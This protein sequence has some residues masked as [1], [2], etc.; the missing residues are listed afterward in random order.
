MLKMKNTGF[1]FR[2]RF[3]LAGIIC[4]AALY[5]FGLALAAL[6]YY[7]TPLP[8]KTMSWVAGGAYFFSVLAAS[9]LVTFRAGGKGLYYGL[10]VAAGFFFLVRALGTAA[11]PSPQPAFSLVQKAVLALAAGFTGG[12]LG[13]FWAAGSE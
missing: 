10:A 2:L 4:A 12:I 7:F 11:P 1:S 3:V 8:E 9:A 6:L 13:A 5:F